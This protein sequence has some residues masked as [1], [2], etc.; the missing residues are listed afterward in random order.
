MSVVQIKTEL[1][2][3]ELLKAIGQLDA[4]E[5]DQVM[6][7]VTLLQAGRKHPNF[8]KKEAELMLEIEK[9]L[10][11]EI[12]RRFDELNE[13]RQAE[14][15]TP[16]E[17]EELLNLVEQIERTNAKRFGYM[18]ELARMRGISLTELMTESDYFPA[19]HG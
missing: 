9:G 13:K 1:H 3:D 10:P 19:D 6:S 18:A 11:P 17:H 15:L 16:S 5:L 8:I 2:F 14:T 12:Q 7:Q 4:D